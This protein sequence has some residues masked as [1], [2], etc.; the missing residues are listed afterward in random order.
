MPTARNGNELAAIEDGG[1][2]LLGARPQ[3][4]FEP[5]LGNEQSPR[6]TQSLDAFV[7]ARD[8][9][10]SLFSGKRFQR[11]DGVLRGKFSL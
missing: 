10:G 7:E 2:G 8:E 9:S 1:A 11:D 5:R 6:P 4:R 3:D